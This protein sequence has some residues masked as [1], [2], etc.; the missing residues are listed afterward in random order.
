MW[1]KLQILAMVLAVMGI[2]QGCWFLAGAAAG[3][4]AAVYA[5]GDL[6]A[7]VDAPVRDTYDATREAMRELGFRMTKSRA[8]A[9]TGEV[10]ALDS[11]DKK[12]EVNLESKGEK[13]TY[14]SIRIG[15]VGDKADSMRILDAIKRNL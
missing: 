11:R 4:A 5:G 3:G 10:V 1:R 13:L 15:I 2:G 6:E 8:D 9:L 7:T 12:I 14:I